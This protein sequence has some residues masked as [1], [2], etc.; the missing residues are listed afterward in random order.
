[1]TPDD[2]LLCNDLVDA[3]PE[4]LVAVDGAGTVLVWNAQA[5]RLLG[6]P[7]ENGIDWS[8]DAT[9]LG[10]DGTTP[11]ARD[12]MPL[13]RAL[14]GERVELFE[15]CRQDAAGQRWLAGAAVP[16]HRDANDDA[17]VTGAVA[18]FRETSLQRRID[19]ARRRERDDARRLSRRLRALAEPEAP[20]ADADAY[21]AALDR[22]LLSVLEMLPA[23]AVHLELPGD[24]VSRRGFDEVAVD[25]PGLAKAIEWVLE[26]GRPIV[27]ADTRD[28]PFVPEQ[29][30]AA[31]TT[32]SY[33]VLPVLNHEQS[34]GA[35]IVLHDDA[36]AINQ[37]DQDFL[38][39]VAG[40]LAAIVSRFRM[41][42]ELNH[43]NHELME[44]R[45]H[46]ERLVAER[47]TEL[48]GTHR[49]LRV[50]DRLAS[51]GTLT[52]GLGHD[53]NNVLFP[54]R[55][56]LQAINWEQVP[57]E[58]REPLD[59][60]MEATS[61][62]QQLCDGLRL[63]ALDPGDADASGRCTDWRTWRDQA[64]PLLE[65]MVPTSARLSIAIAPDVPSVDV[66]PH[67]ITQAILNLVINAVEAIDS[68]GAIDVAID[69]VDGGQWVRIGVTDDGAGMSDEAAAQ[70]FDPFYSTK[71]RE[72]STGLGLSIVHGVVK[73]ADGTIRVT[74][75]PGRGTTFELRLPVGAAPVAGAT[76][77]VEIADA[78]VAAWIESL[79]RTAG[80]RVVGE[81]TDDVDLWV[82]DSGPAHADALR[83]FLAKAGR[84]VIAL[85]EVPFDDPAVFAADAA[86]R[87]SVTAAI[88]AG[89]A[90]LMGKASE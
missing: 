89:L 16:M 66:A 48:E 60:T 46:L 82:T 32:A 14:H 8:A 74:S 35:L 47:T 31:E 26:E 30:D 29:N 63:F 33:A 68:D 67:R 80:L 9:F 11:L 22:L 50:A 62:L 34:L 27:V 57:A 42:D 44:H 5:T 69:G 52:A 49:R 81:Q 1:M 77:R 40:R 79:L 72:M 17:I 55:C 28:D 41:L 13:L 38:A 51:I 58:L 19:A 86:R 70:I 43:L 25:A 18:T 87:T 7:G 75:E 3:L 78:R 65:K 37:S 15:I 53:M 76:A 64:L 21:A 4:G 12:E 10:H 61:F 39:V 59:A 84:G 6:P 36:R 56:R 23:R 2:S 90:H 20:L 54:V 83:H 73:G 71:T 45:D 24:A 85:G 88:D